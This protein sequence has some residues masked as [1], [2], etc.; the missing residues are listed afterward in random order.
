[1]GLLVTKM[2]RTGEGGLS[3]W[4]I[5]LELSHLDES[6]IQGSSLNWKI[7]LGVLSIKNLKPVR[8][9]E[10]LESRNWV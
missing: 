6:R 7:S 1:M 10:K 5:K 9:H 8:P 2:G 3:C 4:G